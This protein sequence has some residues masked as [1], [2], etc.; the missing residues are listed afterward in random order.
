[1]TKNAY[2]VVLTKY[3]SIKPQVPNVS[4]EN[5]KRANPAKARHKPPTVITS[6][7]DNDND[8]DD[9]DYD[10]DTVLIKITFI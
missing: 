1:M 5:N 10:D 2:K 8:D 6:N 4:L 7:D 3:G 9:D